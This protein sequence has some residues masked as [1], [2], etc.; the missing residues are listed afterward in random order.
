MPCIQADHLVEYACG[1]FYEVLDTAGWSCTPAA[2]ALGFDAGGGDGSVKAAARERF[3]VYGLGDPS[4]SVAPSLSLSPI[5]ISPYPLI[6]VF[7]IAL[8]SQP[9]S[10]HSIAPLTLCR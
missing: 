3:E 2:E 10:S 1:K 7:F 4:T 9:L 6:S 8:S 5:P